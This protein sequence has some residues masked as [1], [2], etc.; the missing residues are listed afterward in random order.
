MHFPRW[1]AALCARCS[2]QD[3]RDYLLENLMEEE[4]GYKHT[5]ML[6][7]FGE[8]CGATREQLTTARKLPTTRALT[9]WGD[10]VSLTAPFHEAVARVTVMGPTS[11][12]RGTGIR[13]VAGDHAEIDSMHAPCRS[14]VRSDSKCTSCT[15]APGCSPST[16]RTSPTSQA[17]AVD[18]GPG[19]IG[20]WV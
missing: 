13:S 4:G 8:A 1:V 10:L 16:I 7:T 11:G 20:C 9:D 15:S 14:R 17:H 5:D 3:T 19:M 18:D 2:D 12:R 6:L